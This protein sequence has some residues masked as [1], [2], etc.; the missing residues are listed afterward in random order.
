MVFGFFRFLFGTGDPEPKQ[1]EK[2]EE[3]ADVEEVV[4]PSI[5][6]VVEA[7]FETLVLP[8]DAVELNRLAKEI[9]AQLEAGK[10]ELPALPDIAL[11]V[12]RKVGDPEASVD[13]IVKLI[14]TDAALTAKLIQ[15]ANSPVYAGLEAVSTSAA[16][17]TR[18]GLR[19]T[20]DIVVSISIRSL[21]TSDDATLRARVRGLW[22]HSA[23]VAATSSILARISGRIDP[24]QG[25]VAGLVHDIGELAVLNY[26][27]RSRDRRYAQD[28]IDAAVAVLRGPLGASLIR[29]WRL[30]DD[31]ADAARH[32]EAFTEEG[33]EQASVA[34]VVKLAHLHAFAGTPDMARLPPVEQMPA[35]AKLG[36]DADD[37]D[38]G[39]SVLREARSEIE[40]VR[41]T[42]TS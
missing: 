32:A 6:E 18:M 35:V 42:L 19:A 34:D 31:I 21:F 7:E 4:T 3:T 28:E 13:D 37:P 36:L 24:E 8:E 39:L 29:S 12:S 27:S 17:V 33:S 26:V 20:R 40:S 15:I 5:D 30:G 11:A 9:R 22:E 23:R 41:A 14:R 2:A 16:A 25:M 10:L 1:E 38:Q